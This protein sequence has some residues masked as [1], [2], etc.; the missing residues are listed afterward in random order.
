MTALYIIA[1]IAIGVSVLLAWGA[2][3]LIAWADRA[4]QSDAEDETP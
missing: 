2:M 1:A 4:D 3:R